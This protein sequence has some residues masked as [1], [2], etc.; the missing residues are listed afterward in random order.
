MLNR[1]PINHRKRIP[2]FSSPD[3]LGQRTLTLTRQSENPEYANFPENSLWDAKQVTFATVHV[4]GS[5]NNLADLTEFKARDAANKAWLD[6]VFHHAKTKASRALVIAFHADIFA[7]S[8]MG[9][10]FKTIHN[11]LL[12][13]AALLKKPVLIVHGDYHNYIVDKPYDKSRTPG[14]KFITRLEVYGSPDIK[15]VKVTVSASQK[16]PFSFST[17]ATKETLAMRLKR[18]GKQIKN[19]FN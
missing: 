15:A 8:K 13:G 10:P 9:D 12:A 17:L 14:S 3:S 2:F 11:R 7:K 16:E 6:T 19:H 1:V 18:W 5:H 4:V